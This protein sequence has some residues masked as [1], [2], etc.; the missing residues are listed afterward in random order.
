MVSWIAPIHEIR[1]MLSLDVRIM[2]FA[3]TFSTISN[4]AVWFPMHSLGK[5]SCNRDCSFLGFLSS[6]SSFT[7][8]RELYLLL[9][10][11]TVHILRFTVLPLEMFFRRAP[12][13]FSLSRTTSFARL[14]NKMPQSF[15]HVTKP[16]SCQLGSIRVR[17]AFIT[18][19][20]RISR[21]NIYG[22]SSFWC[23]HWIYT[24]ILQRYNSWIS[25]RLTDV[26]MAIIC[27]RSG[28]I[29][30]QWALSILNFWHFFSFPIPVLCIRKS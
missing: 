18:L 15:Q 25:V 13:C 27:W 26:I 21:T 5:C 17:S 9:S 10:W 14:L 8:S 24:Y 19:F 2:M 12:S 22:L 6:H 11:P 23:S 3:C 4:F 1:R 7:S 20:S 28:I 30:L 16:H 29:W